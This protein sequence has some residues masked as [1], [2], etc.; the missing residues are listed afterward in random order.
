[1][2]GRSPQGLDRFDPEREEEPLDATGEEK[3]LSV[4][5]VVTEVLWEKSC[6]RL[7][8]ACPA[9]LS[10]P[11]LWVLWALELGVLAGVEGPLVRIWLVCSL[12][13]FSRKGTKSF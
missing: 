10:D 6:T 1:M 4:V 8:V 9:L 5:Q 12:K 7:L 3:L 13:K 11:V 2:L